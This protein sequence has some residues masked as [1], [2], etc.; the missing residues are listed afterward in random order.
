M[1]YQFTHT[2]HTTFIRMLYTH[3]PYFINPFR[4]AAI[5]YCINNKRL[6]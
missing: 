6:K 5:L 4:V 2:H 3:F 1:Q